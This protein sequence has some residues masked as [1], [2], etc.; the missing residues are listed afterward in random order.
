MN[1]SPITNQNKGYESD[2]QE[3]SNLMNDNPIA[4]RAS[5]GTFMSQHTQ[6]GMGGTPL[7]QKYGGNKGD[8]SS[9]TKIKVKELKADSKKDY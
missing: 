4:S 1:Y 9:K 5:G 2:G 6:S 8:E 7:M 3:K